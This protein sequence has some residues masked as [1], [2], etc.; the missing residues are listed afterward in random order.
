M[1]ESTRRAEAI[2]EAI[3]AGDDE[4]LGE[5]R[6]ARDREQASSGLGAQSFAAARLAAVVAIGGPA[7]SLRWQVERARAALMSPEEI[8]GV[9]TAIAPQ[10]G[11]PRIVAAAPAIADALGLSTD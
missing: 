9:L 3:I 10:V 5:L 11:F 6:W 7:D 1:T 2:L 4:G 8:I